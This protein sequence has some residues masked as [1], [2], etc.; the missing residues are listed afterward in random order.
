MGSCLR[1]VVVSVFLFSLLSVSGV[2]ATNGDVVA[3]EVAEA[4]RALVLAY[5]AVLEA[6][7]AGANVTSL[8]TRLSAAGEFLSEAYVFVHLGNFE[9]AARLA[10]F[11]VEVADDVEVEAI[12]LRE[13]A[14][15][16]ERADVFTKV[17]GSAVGVVIVVVGGFLLW[18]LYKR[19]YLEKV[20][21]SR[22]EVVS[23]EV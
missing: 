23:V 3:L 12:L 21:D 19:R 17:F 13:E 20:L 22:P 18:S 11:C 10:G 9:G 2:G 8:L 4:E 6:E 1:F 16:I 14:A 7:E 15:R 5:N